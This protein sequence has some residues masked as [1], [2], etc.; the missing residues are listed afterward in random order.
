MQ[1]LRADRVI[2]VLAAA[3]TIAYVAV[4]VG[5]VAVLIATPA[6]R[7]FAARDLSWTFE[8][9]LPL[10]ITSGHV[11]DTRWGEALLMIDDVRGDVRLPIGVLPWWFV[12]LVMAYAACMCALLLA[13]LHQLRRLFQR[14]RDGAPFDPDNATRLRTLGILVFAFA[15]FDG[16]TGFII[17]LIV[18]RGLE[19]ASIPASA[20]MHADGRV[21]LMALLLLALAEIFRRG[22]QLEAEHSL[23]V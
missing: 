14:A 17:A 15:V 7:L 12:G 1:G 16:I 4:W 5:L 19:S 6:I 20:G 11:V 13:G 22:V 2:N 23:V 10:T 18:R 21:L 3:A 9:A 8:L